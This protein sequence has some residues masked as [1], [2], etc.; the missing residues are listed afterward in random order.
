LVGY[1]RSKLVV[2]ANGF[3][4]A[5]LG[6]S[7][8][9]RSELRRASNWSDNEIVVGCVGRFNH[10]KDQEN[11]VRAAGILSKRFANVRFLMIGEGI[12]S[13][14]T[15]LLGWIKATRQADRF[16]LLGH[17]SDVAGWLAAT[18]VFCLS[19]RSEAFP[20]VVGEAMGVGVPCVV[21]DVGDAALLVGDTGIVV[22]KED[23]SAL[24]EGLARMIQAPA[25]V[26]RSLGERATQR[27]MIEFS[28][29]RARKRF[30]AI[31][32][33]LE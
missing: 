4:T 18:D 19:S 27:I 29:D 30:E 8:E 26:R 24:A 5:A 7:R 13:N 12:D 31:Y 2:I 16:K 21:T 14:N 28:M 11:F 6:K 15:E 22:P 9:R 32:S 10:Y 33:S 23:S 3:D 1:Q 17:Q 25:N 20:N